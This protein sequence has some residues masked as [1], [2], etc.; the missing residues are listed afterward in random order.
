MV[1]KSELVN[2]Q[3]KVCPKNGRC[4]RTPS[5]TIICLPLDRPLQT[6]TLPSQQTKRL[7]EAGTSSLTAGACTGLSTQQVLSED[8]LTDWLAM[9]QTLG[10]SVPELVVPLSTFHLIQFPLPFMQNSCQLQ[11][12]VHSPRARRGCEPCIEACSGGGRIFAS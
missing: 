6:Y 11:N 12:E 1:M 10:S 7:L 3:G 9:D 5:C 8:P 2:E 4:L